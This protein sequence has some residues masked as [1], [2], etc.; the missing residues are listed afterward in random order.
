MPGSCPRPCC[1]TWTAPWSTPS[2]YWIAA[3]HELVAEHGGTWSDEHAH[4]LV[5][6]DLLVSAEYI[7]RHGERRPAGRARSSSALLDGVVAAGPRA[8]A[9]APRARASCSPALAAAGVPCAL[10]TMSYRRGSRPR[11]RRAAAR[12]RFAAVVTGDEVDARQAAPRAVPAPPP[13]G[14]A[15]GPRTAWRSRTARP[16]SPRPTAAGVPVVAVPAVVPVPP[17]PGHVVVPTLAGRTAPQ[18]YALALAHRATYA[19]HVGCARRHSPSRRGARTYRLCCRFITIGPPPG[20]LPGA[21]AAG[22]QSRPGRN[23]VCYGRA[24]PRAI[25]ACRAG[26]RDTVGDAGTAAL[27]QWTARNRSGERPHSDCTRG[28]V[29]PGVRAA[30]RGRAGR[31]RQLPSPVAP[32][33]RS[34][35]CGSSATRSRWRGES[36]SSS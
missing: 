17:G 31:D 27:R 13:P 32:W 28:G 24:E 20:H 12:A 16:G 5:G 6:N 35:G 36:S 23:D 22:G 7:R 29:R 18:L 25:G 4:A 30:A 8:R 3:E 10:V 21:R 1:G 34:P 9:V 2:P 33:A 11:S 19:P 15:S 26:S 14:S